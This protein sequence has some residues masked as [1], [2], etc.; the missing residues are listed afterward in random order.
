MFMHEPRHYIAQERAWSGP[1]LVRYE[2]QWFGAVSHLG[3]LFDADAGL[4]VGRLGLEEVGPLRVVVRRH[5]LLVVGRV[6]E[7]VALLQTVNPNT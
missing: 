3:Q 2:P 1:N 4:A 7:P 6:P 5:R